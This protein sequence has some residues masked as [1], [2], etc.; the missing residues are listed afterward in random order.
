MSK[1]T[2]TVAGILGGLVLLW[3]SH[4]RPSHPT[5]NFNTLSEDEEEED[6]QQ[7][8]TATSTDTH[9]QKVGSYGD[10]SQ[11]LLNLLY[12]IADDQARK[13]IINRRLLLPLQSSLPT[14]HEI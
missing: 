3:L 10:E 5:P 13:G 6:D 9:G 8:Y 7:V 1:V 11:N 14:L 2:V 4:R 12:A